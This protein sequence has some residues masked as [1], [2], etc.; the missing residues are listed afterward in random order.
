MEIITEDANVKLAS[1]VFA[2]NK[3]PE[4][5]DGWICLHIT[6]SRLSSSEDAQKTMANTKKLL[7]SCLKNVEGHSF[8]CDPSNILTICRNTSYVV[9]QEIGQH[10]CD[11]SQTE[12]TSHVYFNMFDLTYQTQNFVDYYNKH[13]EPL[14]AF[15]LPEVQEKQAINHSEDMFSPPEE[16][17]YK[18]PDN[19]EKT[20]VLLVEDDPVTRWIVRNALRDECDLTT[21][22]DG[23]KALSL[24]TS[25]QPDIVFLDINLPDKSGMSVLTWIIEHDPGAY[26]VMFSSDDHLST[27]VKTFEKGAKGFIAKPFRK[28]DLLHYLECCPTAH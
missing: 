26:I 20:K 19:K 7:E 3:S 10:I 24:Y 23:N 27:M 15:H 16:K 13:T 21:A 12:D 17:L 18:A 4:S 5:W 6:C 22:Q 2:V 1:L 11:L 9:L 28:E 14:Q 25:Y 8:F